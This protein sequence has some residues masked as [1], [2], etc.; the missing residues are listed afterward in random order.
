MATG[1]VYSLL[2]GGAGVR[3]PLHR[4]GPAWFHIGH[5]KREHL[6]F[7]LTCTGVG[8]R[9]SE[10]REVSG[11]KYENW[12]QTLYFTTQNEG[13]TSFQCITFTN[14]WLVKGA[15]P[16]LQLQPQYHPSLP[17]PGEPQDRAAF[18]L[19]GSPLRKN[20]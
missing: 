13:S 10:A 5:Q 11:I 18:L 2:E 6:A 8:G 15:L 4:A 14:S 1:L 3:V 17:F 20:F 19:L 16:G 7:L 12:S 9:G